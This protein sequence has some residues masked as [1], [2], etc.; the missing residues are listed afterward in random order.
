MRRLAKQEAYKV[1]LSNLFIPAK[2]F[3]I[4]RCK[5]QNINPIS[6]T[7]KFTLDIIQIIVKSLSTCFQYL[8]Q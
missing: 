2:G 5:S 3:L 4:E 7:P 8:V 6:P 1:I